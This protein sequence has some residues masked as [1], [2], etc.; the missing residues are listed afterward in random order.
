MGSSLGVSRQR[1][2]AW[3][4]SES[5]AAVLWQ[6]GMAWSSL[7]AVVD[8][9][10]GRRMVLSG[11]VLLGPVCVFFTGRWLRTALAGAWATC[12]IVILGLPDGIWGSPLETFLIASAVVVAAIGTLALIVT[13]RACLSLTVS[14]SLAAACG[15]PAAPTARRPAV[16]AARPVSC[17]QQYEDWQHGPGFAQYSRLR[18]DVNAV[19]AAEKSGNSVALRSA[20]KKLMPAVLANGN[21]DPVPRC[22]DPAGRYDSY[23]TRIYTA[24]T[25][26]ARRAGSAGC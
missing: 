7:V 23:L 19:R 5:S 6:F 11:L 13:I 25:T 20:M 15:G 2:Q 26:R 9:S 14:A 3:A 10:T 12:L 21:P 1:R 24:G 4:L 18:A 8:V 22:A 16:S 17:R